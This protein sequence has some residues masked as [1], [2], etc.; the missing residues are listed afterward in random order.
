[1]TQIKSD[2][3]RVTAFAPASCANLAVGFDILGLAFDSVGDTVALEKRDDQKLLIESITGV[4]KIPFGPD[5][6]T[7]SVALQGMLSHLKLKQGFS[8]H[9]QKGIPM[10]S[11][12]GGSAASAVAAVLACNAF[13]KKPLSLLELAQFALL[14]E[15]AASGQKHADNV[16]PSL[17]G[18]LT[19]IKSLDP[20]EIV[21]LPIP[22]LYCVLVHPHLEVS[23]QVARKI[24][25]PQLPLSDYV[26]QS[27][28][29][30]AFIAGLYQN[31]LELLEAS[32]RDY[33]IEPQ[34][35]GFVPRFYALKQA[36]L[37]AGALGFCLS[38]SGPSLLALVKQESTAK[39]V[40]LVMQNQLKNEKLDADCWIARIS[41][42]GARVTEL[43]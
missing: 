36:A 14:G 8:L 39:K 2:I 22:S 5:K 6:N 12:M 35:A 23:T 24:L 37:D 33:L 20:L 18:G 25:K 11:G 7:A 10:S 28:Q 13:L 38:G 43:K 31:N 41:E 34:R 15:Q 3:Q 19:L 40:A 16:A 26:K 17:F 1:M 42:E 9:I 21:Q 30:A 29:L 27:A 4:E 32:F